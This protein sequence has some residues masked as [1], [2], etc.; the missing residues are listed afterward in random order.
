MS[1]LGIIPTLKRTT[2]KTQA[3]LATLSDVL[4][5]MSGL[6]NRTNRDVNE[7]FRTL[8]TSLS[9]TEVSAG[10]S[11][12]QLGACLALLKETLEVIVLAAKNWVF[13]HILLLDFVGI[14]ILIHSL[15][16]FNNVNIKLGMSYAMFMTS[17]ICLPGMRN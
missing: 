11:K 17:N 8:K 3:D 6:Q 1:D 16:W 5:E 4:S 7:G 15:A 13:H 9:K 12:I 10:Q 2:D 14:R